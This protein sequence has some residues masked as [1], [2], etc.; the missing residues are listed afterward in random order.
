VQDIL[1]EKRCAIE[2]ESGNVEVHW[3]NIKMCA[4]Y[5]VWYDCENR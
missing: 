4:R 3:N 5:Y 1:E 2:C